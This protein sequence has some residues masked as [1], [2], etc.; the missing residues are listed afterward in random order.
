M[1]Q[2]K[3]T[4]G[5]LAGLTLAIT[6][7]CRPAVAS[8]P[9]L[10][11][12]LQE[13]RQYTGAELVFRRDDLPE[14]RYH[15]VMKPLN[16]SKRKVTAAKICLNEARLY[17][18]RFFHEAGFKTVGVFAACVSKTTT[19]PSRTYDVE[20]GG[21]R[22]FG[23]Y[24]GKNAIAASHY[25]DGQLALTFHH[26]IFHH[27]DSTVDGDTA[28]WQL[29]SDDAFFQAAI[30]GMRPYTAPPIEA[31]DLAKLKRQRIGYTL[32]NAVSD[33]AAKNS[34]EDQAET[35]RHLMSMLSSSL[36]QAIEKPHLPGSQRILHVLH[37]YEQAVPD[38]PSF[39]WFVDVALGRAQHTV[40]SETA[41]QLIAR[42]RTLATPGRTGFAGVDPNPAAARA[43]LKLVVR[44]PSGSIAAEQAT[45]MVTLSAGITHALLLQRIRPD[46]GHKTFDIWGQEDAKGI[47]HTLRH[48][49]TQ[50][51]RDARRLH[52]IGSTHKSSPAILT[53]THC[54]NLR[55][56]ARYFDYIQR[57]WS[58]SVGTKSAFDATKKMIVS[59]IPATDA[60]IAG[61]LQSKNLIEIARQMDVDGSL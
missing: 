31:E 45:E 44:I 22:Y 38:G 40:P 37:E 23:V 30:S 51:A 1:Q 19:D 24:N 21:Y 39:D 57:N 12:I 2:H 5:I 29:S 36:V 7:F 35:A 52:V 56:I 61:T 42:L 32:K 34:R 50:F 26:E 3:H 8:E 10:E 55:L 13:F 41:D 17:P 60:G 18:P 46:A 47:N 28:S 16:N 15:D 11:K 58:V 27:I 33:Y 9:E 20:L 48:D 25:S 43:A 59:S 14:G 4:F 49:L 54:K 53:Q 6:S